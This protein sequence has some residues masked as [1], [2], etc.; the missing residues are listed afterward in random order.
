MVMSPDGV[1]FEDSC[2]FQN[3]KAGTEGVWRKTHLSYRKKGG[4]SVTVKLPPVGNKEAGECHIANRSSSKGTW[5]TGW[6]HKLQR[7]DQVSMV[8]VNIY[9]RRGE[10]S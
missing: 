1:P 10:K 3:F 5:M 9:Y 7:K 6:A 2:Y 4:L 8:S